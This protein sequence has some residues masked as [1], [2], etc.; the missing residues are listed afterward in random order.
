MQKQKKKDTDTDDVQET[1][2]FISRLNLQRHLLENFIDPSAEE[3]LEWKNSGN[4]ADMEIMEDS[5]D[6]KLQDKN[7]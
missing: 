6:S 2:K 1:K 4:P 5:E 7:K 3:L